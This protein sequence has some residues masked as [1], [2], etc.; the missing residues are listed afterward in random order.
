MSNYATVYPL[1]TGCFAKAVSRTVER[2]IEIFLEFLKIFST[3]FFKA[4]KSA[5][6][7]SEQNW[8]IL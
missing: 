7:E 6:S 8:K 5:P 4:V 2:D 1:I 3:A